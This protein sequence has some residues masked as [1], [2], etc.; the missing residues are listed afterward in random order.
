MTRYRPRPCM[1]CIALILQCLLVIL[2]GWW[3]LPLTTAVVTV[4]VVRG[5]SRRR[6][7]SWF[8]GLLVLLL[9]VLLAR[10]LGNGIVSQLRPWALY[11]LRLLTSLA[12]AFIAYEELGLVSIVRTVS[13]AATLLPGA[14]LRRF[15]DDTIRSVLF[16]LPVVSRRLRAAREA[17]VLRRA[18]LRRNALGGVGRWT[19][20]L[21]IVYISSLAALPRGRAEA[22]L[23]RESR[24]K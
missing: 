6:L 7:F 20:R 13:L 2:P 16:L 5:Y 14:A 12:I 11:S 23:I 17:Y 9:A 18:H 10:S 21:I 3:I 1:L 15:V 24:W 4:I 8:R 22:L 19:G